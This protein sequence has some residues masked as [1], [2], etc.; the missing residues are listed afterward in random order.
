[1]ADHRARDPDPEELLAYTGAVHRSLQGR[2][3]IIATTHRPYAVLLAMQ[4]RDPDP[5]PPRLRQQLLAVCDSTESVRTHLPEDAS[6]VVVFF[7]DEKLQ[8]GSILPLLHELRQR[9]APPSVVLTLTPPVPAAVVQAAWRAGVQSLLCSDDYGHGELAAGMAALANGERYCGPA[10]R[11]L[12]ESAGPEPED[13][14]LREQ[15]VLQHLASGLTNRQIAEQLQ[16]AEVTARDHV[17]RILQKLRVQNRGAAA[18][19]AVRLGL[20][21]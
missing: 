1:M 13:L 16:I 15:D 11:D 21:H 10:F 2:P 7:L 18:A 17:N 8:D 4:L 3:L 19:L 14:T 20:V 6:D 9:A 12:V 5:E